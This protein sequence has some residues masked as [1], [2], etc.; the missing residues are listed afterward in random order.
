MSAL[1]SGIREAMR[2][3]NMEIMNEAYEGLLR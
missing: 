1:S 2:F 3:K